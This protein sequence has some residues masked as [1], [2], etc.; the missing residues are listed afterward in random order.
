MIAR[1]IIGINIY[2][3]SNNLF[4]NFTLIIGIIL[5]EKSV[6]MLEDKFRDL[7]NKKYGLDS[8]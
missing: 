1:K 2:Q 8:K 5:T 3:R 7:P 6:E 4:N